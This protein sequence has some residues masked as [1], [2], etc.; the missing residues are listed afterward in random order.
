MT[1]LEY[2]NKYKI[3][4]KLGKAFVPL[5]DLFSAFQD[6]LQ[7]LGFESVADCT[8]QR[9]VV[10]VKIDTDTIGNEGDI[11]AFIYRYGKEVTRFTIFPTAEDF[12][13]LGMEITKAENNERDS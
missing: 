3:L 10:S 1:A 4:R 6:G 5:K 8:R 7:K 9:G 13:R 12:I 2:H 11:K